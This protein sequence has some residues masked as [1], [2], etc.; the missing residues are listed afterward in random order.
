MPIVF[1]LFRGLTTKSESAWSYVRDL[2]RGR[3]RDTTKSSTADSNAP[4]RKME[5]PGELPQVPKGTLTGLMS[6]VR[7]N[8]RTKNRSRFD[9]S[10]IGVTA[11]TETLV[12]LEPVNQSYHNYLHSPRKDLQDNQRVPRW[13]GAPQWHGSQTVIESDSTGTRTQRSG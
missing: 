5:T 11:V 1:V 3:S 12:E 8:G 13:D 4:F 7:G 2:V 6:F 10:H 9:N